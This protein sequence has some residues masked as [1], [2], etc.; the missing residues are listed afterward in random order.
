MNKSQPKGEQQPGIRK[1]LQAE[2]KAQEMVQK[3]RRDKVARLKQAKEEAE[4]E[5]EAYRAKREAE[6][7]EYAGQFSTSGEDYNKNLEQKTDG[8]IKAL[9]ESAVAGKEK[10]IQLLFDTVKK[11]DLDYDHTKHRD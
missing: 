9:Q 4:K 5:V 2:Q 3:A 8:E 11:V 10:V 1:L 6:F 7:G